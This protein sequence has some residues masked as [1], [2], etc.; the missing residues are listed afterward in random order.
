MNLLS[1]LFMFDPLA[2]SL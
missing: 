2:S 1:K